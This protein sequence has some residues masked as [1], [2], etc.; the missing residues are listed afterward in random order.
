MGKYRG[1]RAKAL[2]VENGQARHVTESEM[3]LYPPTICVGAG[4]FTKAHVDLYD[5][6]ANIVNPCIHKVT[7][8]HKEKSSNIS[9]TGISNTPQTKD[10]ANT[11][12]V[13]FDY[14]NLIKY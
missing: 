6:F 4:H 3:K 11:L 14:L 13:L 10:D 1:T 7:Y 5:F 2:I 12:S 8:F 9:I